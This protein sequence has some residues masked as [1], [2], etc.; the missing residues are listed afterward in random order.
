[1]N[2]CSLLLLLLHVVGSLSV[3]VCGNLCTA[4][5]SKLGGENSDGAKFRSVTESVVG[6]GL[7]WLVTVFA[8]WVDPFS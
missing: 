2:F 6:A 7:K 5:V 4:V 1:M 8:F 3:V